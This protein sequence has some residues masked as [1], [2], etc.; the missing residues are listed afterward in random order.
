MHSP[1]ET[2]IVNKSLFMFDERGSKLS[3]KFLFNYLFNRSFIII[4]ILLN[5]KINFYYSFLLYI[6]SLKSRNYV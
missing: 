3:N 5:E 4:L 6:F 2:G 1:N